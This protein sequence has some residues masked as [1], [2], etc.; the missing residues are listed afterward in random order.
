MP[1]RDN[2]LNTVS[3]AVPMSSLTYYTEDMPPFNY[4]ENGTLQGLSIDLLEAITAKMGDKVSRDQVRLVPWSE[5][6]Q[7]A[8]TGNRTVIFA[9][10]RNPGR[11]TSFKWAGPISSVREVLFALPDRGITVRSLS[12]LKGY[13]IGAVAD[14]LAVQQLREAGVSE[15]QLVIANNATVLISE[16]ERGE[17]DLWAY[18]E[19][20][21]RYFTEQVTGNYYRFS[22]VYS[23]PAIDIYYAFSRDVPDSTVQSFQQALDAL[24]QEKDAR[25][26]QC[27]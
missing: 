13:R 3:A 12:D 21:G 15:D 20:A 9:I 10:A 26:N 5:G 17:I 16:L 27:L 18:P 6:Y 25:G 8:L 2:P 14:D 11:E 19:P 1:D 24:K 23:F 22:V 7:A 4:V